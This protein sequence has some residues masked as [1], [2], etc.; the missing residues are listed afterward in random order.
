MFQKRVER[1]NK[2]YANPFR[3]LEMEKTLE[4][5][6]LEANEERRRTYLERFGL[7]PEIKEEDSLLK[8]FN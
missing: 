8:D 1:K 3:G 4:Q 7:L 5:L 6:R 2:R